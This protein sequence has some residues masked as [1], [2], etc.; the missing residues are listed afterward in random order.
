MT[1]YSEIIVAK[2]LYKVFASL[3]ARISKLE[4]NE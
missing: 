1:I 4:G 2:Q 3:D